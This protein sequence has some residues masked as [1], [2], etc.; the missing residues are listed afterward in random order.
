MVNE[1]PLVSVIIT[2]YNY[3]QYI[4]EALDTVIAQTY[5]NIELIVIDDGSTD[6]SVEI[7]DQFKKE[8]PDIVVIK[9]KNKGV[10]DTRNKGLD[11][12]NGEYLLFIDADDTI[13]NDFIE[14]MYKALVKNKADVA[15]CDLKLSEKMRG[16]IEVE[17]PSIENLIDFKPSPV[18]QLI[19]RSVIGSIRFDRKLDNLAHEDNDFFFNLFLAGAKFTKAKTYYNYRIHGEGRSP[20]EHNE[21]HYAARLYIY[22]KYNNKDHATR[23]L[24]EKVLMKKEYEI[25]KWHTVADERLATI[26][27][28]DEIVKDLSRQRGDLQNKLSEIKNSKRYKIANA[29]LAPASSIKSILNKKAR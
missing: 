29:I 21:K 8:H 14:E 16:V 23:S 2:N 7:I 27:S 11:T 3:G 1:Q 10:V 22:Q 18:C 20:I 4:K 17:S 9:Q 12:A 13:P 25:K 19:K 15:Y 6:D 28:T 24:L 26:E 5:K